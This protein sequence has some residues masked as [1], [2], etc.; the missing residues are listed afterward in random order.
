MARSAAAMYGGAAFLSLV[1]GLAPGGYEFA[2]APGVGALVLGGVVLAFGTRLPQ[3]VLFLLGPLGAVMIGFALADAPGPGDGAVLYMW[4]VLWVAYFFG[5]TETL[6]IV[7]CLAV[8]HAVSL[9][10]LDVGDSFFDRWLDVMVVVTVV[11]VV[12]QTLARRNAELLAHSAAEARV[13]KLTG[14][15]NR[16][17]FEERM[18]AELARASRAGRPIA[19]VSFDIDYFKRVNDEWGH[20]A[21]DR[22]LAHLGDVFR[23]RTRGADIV[24]RMGGE[25]F[26]AVLTDCGLQQAQGY[27]E[28]VRSAF[29]GADLGLGHVTIS[30]GVAAAE[31]PADPEQLLQAADSAL[32]AAKCRGRDQTVVHAAAQLSAA[33]A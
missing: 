22:V 19:V 18:P 25:E 14:L 21:G 26:V 9:W 13:D 24:A 27:A 17:G 6:L 4:P 32:Y 8:V 20:D 3:R 7:G 15:L 1:Q 2:L 29:S 11:A 31:A 16:R 28:R 5:R 33:P 10:S 30:A 23:L 12:V